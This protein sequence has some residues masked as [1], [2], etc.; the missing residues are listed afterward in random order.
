MYR[1]CEKIK[2]KF[3]R[4]WKY[5]RNMKKMMKGQKYKRKS[6]WDDENCNEIRIKLWNIENFRKKSIFVENSVFE[7]VWRICEKIKKIMRQK[8]FK[9]K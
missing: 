1:I 9:W 3:M 4:W 6:S 2:K 8:K 5:R 7:D